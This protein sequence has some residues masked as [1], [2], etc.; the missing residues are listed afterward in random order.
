[1]IWIELNKIYDTQGPEQGK[2]G[3][4]GRFPRR[5]KIVVLCADG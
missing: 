1:M 4:E 5:G 3:H 2:G